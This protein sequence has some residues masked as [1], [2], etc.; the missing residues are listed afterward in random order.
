VRIHG[1]DDFFLLSLSLSGCGPLPQHIY[2]TV[3]NMRVKYLG[4][5]STNC[6]P[7]K[8]AA[9]LATAKQGASKNQIKRSAKLNFTQID[10][11]IDFMLK[12]D[13]LAPRPLPNE[14]YL[15]TQKGKDFLNTTLQKS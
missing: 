12:Q 15:T 10:R 2:K 3:E 11:Y 4:S 9:V 13:L 5:M 8:I 6:N 1:H 14:A 7:Q